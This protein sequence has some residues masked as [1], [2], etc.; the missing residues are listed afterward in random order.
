MRPRQLRP[1][2]APYLPAGRVAITYH[3]K[4]DL[5]SDRKRA[6]QQLKLT[7]ADGEELP[8]TFQLSKHETPQGVVWLIDQLLVKS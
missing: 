8:V 3:K 6:L 2:R 4:L 1:H 7:A 5:S